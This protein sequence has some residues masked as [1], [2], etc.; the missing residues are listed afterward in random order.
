MLASIK[1]IR[2]LSTNMTVE[3]IRSHGALYGKLWRR[4]DAIPVPMFTENQLGVMC[5]IRRR[6]PAPKVLFG[7]ADVA[8]SLAS[9]SL[10]VMVLLSLPWLL[11]DLTPGQEPSI[12]SQAVASLEVAA[13][14][15]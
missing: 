4:M 2:M 6:I 12:V 14:A 5:R 8:T 3:M 1:K 10:P 15:M 9:T 11:E 7:G 13:I